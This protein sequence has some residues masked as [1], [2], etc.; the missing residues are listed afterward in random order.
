MRSCEPESESLPQYIIS[1]SAWSPYMS[2]IR[3]ASGR[4]LSWG[5]WL[6]GGCVAWRKAGTCAGCRSGPG[7]HMASLHSA[8]KLEFQGPLHVDALIPCGAST[9]LPLIPSWSHQNNAGSAGIIRHRS[10]W[11][12]LGRGNSGNSGHGGSWMFLFFVNLLAPL[13]L[14]KRAA[15]FSFLKLF[16]LSTGCKTYFCSPWKGST[17]FCTSSTKSSAQAEGMILNTHLICNWKSMID[18]LNIESRVQTSLLHVIHC[19]HLQFCLDLF[20]PRLLGLYWRLTWDNG[21]AMARWW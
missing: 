15:K 21:W 1:T 13:S 2:C 6:A 11:S 7:L 8:G 18:C 19:R 14:A 5:C 3:P 4:E 20:G 10:L 9:I 16:L 12:W 17:K